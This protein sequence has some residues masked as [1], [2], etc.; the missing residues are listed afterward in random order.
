MQTL[1]TPAEVIEELGGF[2]AVADITGV[3][4]KAA[5]N[6]KSFETL[7]SKTYIALI[8]ALE[9]KGKTAPAS[10]WGMVEPERAAS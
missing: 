6:W 8:R 4:P 9:A 10:L 5:F 3:K 2:R 7:P 1:C